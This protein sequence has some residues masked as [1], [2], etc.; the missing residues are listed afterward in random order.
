[1]DDICQVFSQCNDC[2]ELKLRFFIKDKQVL[3]RAS[4]PGERVSMDSKKPLRSSE[5]R[6][7]LVLIDEFSRFRCAFPCRN[8]SA[9]TVISR[10]STLFS[11]FGF[12]AYIHSDRGSSFMSQEINTYLHKRGIATSLSTLLTTLRGICDVKSLIKNH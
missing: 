10:L 12:P 7:L 6:Y 8:L 11:L 5:N 2:A 1:M 3:I 4:Q 9:K